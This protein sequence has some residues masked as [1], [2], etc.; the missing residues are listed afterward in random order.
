[1]AVRLTF[2]CFFCSEINAKVFETSSKNGHNV[3]ELALCFM[4]C[5]WKK[6]HSKYFVWWQSSLPTQEGETGLD[7][8]YEG[9]RT[10]CL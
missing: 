2:V 10:Q 4:N 1:M 5:Y 8:V 3:G 6:A 9:L 7:I